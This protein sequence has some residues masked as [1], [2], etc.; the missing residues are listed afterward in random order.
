MPKTELSQQK[1]D[2]MLRCDAEARRASGYI[3][4]VH[5]DLMVAAC[6]IGAVQLG[7]RHP[8]NNGRSAKLARRILDAMIQRLD[9]DGFPAYAELCRLGFD[10]KFDE[11]RGAP[12]AGRDRNSGSGLIGNLRQK[13]SR[14]SRLS[15]SISGCFF[16]LSFSCQ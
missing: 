14:L 6:L 8:A 13:V 5:C 16:H 12:C 15:M 11:E 4:P 1:R 3:L 7:L 2:L 10:P 9:E